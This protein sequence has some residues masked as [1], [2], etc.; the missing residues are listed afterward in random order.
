MSI[1]DEVSAFYEGLRTLAPPGGEVS[2]HNP[3]DHEARKAA[4]KAFCAKFYDD[5]AP[6]IHLLGINP[7]KPANTSTGVHYTD[8]YALDAHCGIENDFS[9]GR[10]LTSKFFYLVVEALGGAAMFYERV[11]AWSMMPV[12]ATEEGEYRNYYDN[13]VRE[14]VQPVVDHNLRWLADRVPCT[15]RAV[16]LGTGE[17]KA[18]F[19][20]LDGYPFGYDEVIYLPHPRWILQYHSAEL[21]KHVESY[22]HALS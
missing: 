3:F 22:V 2:L 7:N 21:E 11:F 18:N 13:G 6:R 17:N 9:K 8:G 16:V 15:G 10:E 12:C 14:L 1:S 20:A 19:E 4:I 5:D